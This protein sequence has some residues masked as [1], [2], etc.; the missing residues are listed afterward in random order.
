[1]IDFGRRSREGAPEVEMERFE[2]LES[3]ARHDAQ[4]KEAGRA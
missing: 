3:R 2:A 4:V 1:L